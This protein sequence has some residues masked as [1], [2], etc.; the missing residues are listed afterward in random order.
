MKDSLKKELKLYYEAPKPQKKQAF[1]RQFGVQKIDIF[2]LSLMQAK[3]ISKWIW[4]CSIFFCG[5]LYGMGNVLEGKYIGTVAAFLPFLVMLSVTESTRSYRYGMEELELSARFS[6]K[7]IVMARMCILGIGNAIVLMITVLCIGKWV[8]SNL[9][10]MITPYFLSVGG[11]FY[12]V[13]TIRGSESTFFCFALAGIISMVQGLF[14]FYVQII[15]SAEYLSVWAV[16]CVA[17][18]IMTGKESYRMIQMTEC[19]V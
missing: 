16:I 10:Y 13:R 18:I 19:L 15:F 4:V 6:L 17:A 2:S 14:P 11:G 9:L 7:S 8:E 3:Y 12:I 5:L 1:L